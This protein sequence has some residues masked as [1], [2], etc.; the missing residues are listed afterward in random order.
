MFLELA[1]TTGAGE[2]RPHRRDR[3]QRRSH[4][5]GLRGRAHGRLAGLARRRRPGRLATLEPAAIAQLGLVTL[6]ATPVARVA[7]SVVGFALEGD[8]LYAAITTGVLVILLISIL[9]LR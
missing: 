7:A 4:R 5:S 6:L 3:H 2:W 1:T 9:V 8:R